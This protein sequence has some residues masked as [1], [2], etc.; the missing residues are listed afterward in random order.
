MGA[1][2]GVGLILAA[3][4]LM[5]RKTRKRRDHDDGVPRP[6]SPM[7]H[8]NRYEDDFY[9]DPYQ[10]AYMSQRNIQDYGWSTSTAGANRNHSVTYTATTASNPDVSHAGGYYAHQ[11]YV[12]AS[13]MTSVPLM[14]SS[15]T[16][17]PVPHD[18]PHYRD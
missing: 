15:P 17:R 11:P 16:T 7:D 18:V 13:R 6:L 14:P 10:N 4:F 12:D 2:A 9:A 8:N 3:I 5:L 1:T